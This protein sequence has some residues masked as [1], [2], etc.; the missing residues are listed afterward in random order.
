MPDHHDLQRFLDAQADVI[1]RVLDELRAGRKRS[2]WMR[3]IFPQIAGL[4]HSVTAQVYAI[5]SLDE[6]QAYADHPVLGPRLVDCSQLV[7]AAATD[8]PAAIFGAVDALKFRS[9]MTLFQAAK[10]EEPAFAA[11]LARFYAGEPDP[12]TLDLL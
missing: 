9:S 7:L 11:A 5:R 12:R 2:H 4:G 10:P 6:A 1:D 3:F 8:D